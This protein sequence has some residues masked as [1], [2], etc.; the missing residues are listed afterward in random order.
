MI[1]FTPP[2]RFIVTILT[3]WIGLRVLF[4]TPANV[5]QLLLQSPNPFLPGLPT[6]PLSGASSLG[7]TDTAHPAR[8]ALH[9]AA[10]TGPYQRLASIDPERAFTALPQPQRG[11]CGARC[12]RML[13]AAH[14]PPLSQPMLMRFARRR[15]HIPAHGPST[16]FTSPASAPRF[17][18]SAWAHWRSGDGVSALADDGELGGS[19]AGIRA[20]YRIMRSAGIEAAF[21][22]RLSR[23]IE[24]DNGAEAAIG[25]AIR[26]SERVPI[27]LVA[28]RRIGLDDGGR[29]AWSLGIAGGLYRHPLPFGFELDGYAQAGI[30]GARRRD[31]YGD[32]ALT[33]S[34]PIP[35]SA[36]SLSER[37]TLS[38][39]GGVWA[40]AQQGASR[41]DIGPE[42]SIRLPVGDGGVRLSVSWRQRIA[43]SAAPGSG[44]VL[45]LGTDF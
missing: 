42:A 24:Q 29:D 10:Q 23:P 45:T 16:P 36:T 35:L 17:S 33:V 19:Q 21:A 22:A 8:E 44:P 7:E 34:Q 25:I 18:V 26:P 38:L 40:G 1:K 13:L 3:L 37:S 28:E 32:A 39:G 4:W 9:T 27:E 31:L 41:V 6:L 11:S 30:V 12:T 2:V 43:G 14:M 20:R 15:S 5:P